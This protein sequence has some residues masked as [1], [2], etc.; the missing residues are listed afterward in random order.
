VPYESI[1]VTF[2]RLLFIQ[3]ETDKKKQY[4]AKIG[5]LQIDQAYPHYMPNPVILTPDKYEE[6]TK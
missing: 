4:Q 1:V 6:F 5:F 2:R 3:Y